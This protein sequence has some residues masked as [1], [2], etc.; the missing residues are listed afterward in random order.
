MPTGGGDSYPLPV[1]SDLAEVARAVRDSGQWAWVVDSQWRC[2]YVTDELRRSN[3]ADEQLMPVALGEHMFGPAAIRVAERWPVGTNSAELYR[4]FFRGV[5][6]MV[7][8]DTPGGRE[9]L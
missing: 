2:V 4:G 3:G 8:A 5:G 7:I 1:D 6:G 9:E